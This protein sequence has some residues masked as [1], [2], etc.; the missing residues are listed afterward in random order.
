MPKDPRMATGIVVSDK[1]QKTIVVRIDRRVR[2][3]L[4][5]KIVTK[6]GKLRAHDETNQA[7]LGDRVTVVESKPISKTKFWRLLRVE[8]RPER[9]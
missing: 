5:G 9:V 3:P 6:S 4:Y 7:M 2:H 1:M 8:S